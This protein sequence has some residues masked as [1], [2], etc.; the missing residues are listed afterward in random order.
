M[1]F[2]NKLK[3]GNF[4]C[5]HKGCER[6]FNKPTVITDSYKIPRETH[7][8]CPYCNSKLEIVTKDSQAI[9][10][11]TAQNPKVFYLPAE[12]TRGTAQMEEIN[13]VEIH[14]N[15]KADETCSDNE[16]PVSVRQSQETPKEKTDQFSNFQCSY[17]FGYLSEK[18]RNESVPETC[19]GCPR[20]I[21]CMLS[22]LNKSQESLAEIKKWYS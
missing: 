2:L 18:N 21:D 3:K 19:F 6:E 17:H 7:Y 16:T 20:S 12:G 8:A 10:V 9:G 11:N 13:T 1:R 22:E 14:S 4:K 15:K 5:P